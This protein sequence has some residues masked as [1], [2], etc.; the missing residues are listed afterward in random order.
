MKGPKT[1]TEK[2][3]YKL[4]PRGKARNKTKEAWEAWN[5]AM[6]MCA[7]AARCNLHIP[8]IDNGFQR[9]DSCHYAAHNSYVEYMKAA[10]AHMR[11]LQ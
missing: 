5:K 1:Y 4:L 10:K 8:S 9:W 11:E 7:N 3:A 2:K 6:H